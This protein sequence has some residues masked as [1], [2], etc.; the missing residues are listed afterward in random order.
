MMTPTPRPPKALHRQGGFVTILAVLFVILFVFFILTKTLSLLGNKSIDSVQYL[1]GMKAL[2]IAESGA[3]RAV[4]LISN[5]VSA[6]DSQ[7]D[8]ACAASKLDN[9]NSATPIAFAGGT[10]TY[11]SS[12]SPPAPV[13]TCDVRV[14]GTLNS[15]QRTVQTRVDVSSEIGTAGYGHSIS[16]QLANN[17]NVPG[18]AVFN[19]AWRR[20][21]STGQSPPGGQSV[22]S[23][24]T[25]PSCGLQ[26]SIDSSSGLPSVGSLGTAVGIAAHT[27]VPVTQ[28][29]SLDRNYAEVGMVMPG[30]VG[31]PL[32]IGS[33]ADKKN[34][35]NTQ[36]QTVTSGSTGS[37]EI[38]GWCN[39]ADT[40]VF[41]VSGRGNDDVT[42]A[43]ASVVF[44][45]SGS[46]AQPIPLTWIAHFPNT[47]GSTPNVFGDVFSEIWY[48]YNP[49]VKFAGA[50]SSGNTVT[51]LS[52]I[53]LKAGTLLKVYSG[54]GQFAGN[55][56]VLNAVTSQTQFQVTAAPTTPLS[57][58]T[59][60]GGICAL[61]DN[62]S[63]AGSSTSFS[64]T[65]A[66]AAAQQWA[67]GFTCLSGVDPTKVHRIARSSARIGQWNEVISGY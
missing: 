38:L 34:T 2:F 48:T 32:V 45:T 57:N 41:G 23:A 36:N 47:D 67:G 20:S 42:A 61:F 19:L 39:A 11:A 64:L 27:S 10:I 51:V 35:G 12:I 4:G 65:R 26:W 55:T 14:T 50:T 52:P 31:Q 60:C 63:S 58:A 25:L 62:P 21:G 29:L 6:D 66:T 13:G 53:T 9:S 56:K 24:C 5:M 54:T 30:L 28:T 22:G 37:G 40:L 7:L 59:V 8:A 15:A 43:F 18:V 16:M 46:P 33:Y 3:E 1:N 17:T 44:N 49:Y